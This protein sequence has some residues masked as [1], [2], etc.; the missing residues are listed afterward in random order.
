MASLPEPE[1][2]DKENR[3]MELRRLGLTWQEIADNVGY[4]THVGAWKAYKRVMERYQKEPREDLQNMEV[5]RL[6]RIM[7]T[8]MQKAIVE[9]NEKAAIIALRAIELRS[10]LLGLNEP[11]KIQQEITTWDG[12]E[13]I[14]RSVKEL[15]ALLRANSANSTSQG[16]L[17]DNSSEIQPITTE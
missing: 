5:E 8:F 16:S 12:D 15:A 13:S 11:T 1:Q 17:G 10:K 9:E 7:A 14:D 2:L 3:V 6:N 4:A